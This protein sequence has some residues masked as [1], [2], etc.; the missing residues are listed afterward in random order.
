M[1]AC[2]IITNASHASGTAGPNSQH[3]GSCWIALISHV[4]QPLHERLHHCCRVR[5]AHANG[6][7]SSSPVASLI[8]TSSSSSSSSSDSYWR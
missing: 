7:Y 1:L 5:P 2:A 8:S 4:G 6:Q 3:A